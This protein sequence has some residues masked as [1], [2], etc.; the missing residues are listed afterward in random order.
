MDAW[1]LILFAQHQPPS[2]NSEFSTFGLL[3]IGSALLSLVTA[4]HGAFAWLV[5]REPK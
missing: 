2:S 4:A 1:P 5:L 3:C